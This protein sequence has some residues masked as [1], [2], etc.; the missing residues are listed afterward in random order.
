MLAPALISKL[1]SKKSWQPELVEQIPY[2]DFVRIFQPFTDKIYDIDKNPPIDDDMIEIFAKSY[3]TA[4]SPI[5]AD[6]TQ[7]KDLIKIDSHSYLSK[8]NG[9]ISCMEYTRTI[10]EQGDQQIITLMICSADNHIPTPHVGISGV[11]INSEDGLIISPLDAFCLTNDQEC[12]YM[13]AEDKE[14]FMGIINYANQALLQIIAGEELNMLENQKWV[15]DKKLA[16]AEFDYKKIMNRNFQT[17]FQD[18]EIYKS[19]KKPENTYATG[20]VI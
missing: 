6:L 20:P 11:I 17:L 9:Y 10:V 4:S 18:V 16:R 13:C 15:S 1:F 12:P 19:S 14:T 3:Q 8:N 7:N 5:Y 2:V